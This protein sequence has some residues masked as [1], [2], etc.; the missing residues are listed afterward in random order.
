MVLI[1]DGA[2]TEEGPPLPP[3]PGF[4]VRY[5][6]LAGAVRNVGHLSSFAGP[7]PSLPIQARSTPALA[8]QN[9]GPQG[10]AASLEIVAEGAVVERRPLE[11]GPVRAPAR[12]PSATSSP[13]TR[14]WEARVGHDRRPAARRR[15]RHLRRSRAR[16]LGLRGGPS[17]AAPAG[18]ARRWSGSLSRRRAPEPE[19]RTVTLERATVSDAAARASP[20]GPATTSSSSTA[21]PPA[22]R[23][24]PGVTS[25]WDPH[26]EGSPSRCAAT[27]AIPVIAESRREHPL[28][29]Q[30][31]L[32]DVNI[33]EARRLTLAS[34]DVAVA[35]S[36]GVPVHH[37]PRAP[38][39]A[40][41]RAQLRS[42]AVPIC[43]CAPPIH[44]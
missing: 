22:R 17:P 16:R 9:F 21:S 8:V 30:V 34:G 32:A 31:D 18:V 14:A 43:R 15:R 37:C 35:G 4:D 13:P 40:R 19:A 29:R 1:S 41:R 42:L 24:R 38:R 44:C 25:I 20:P 36:F 5:L 27:D 26:G 23:P 10:V 6:P 39:T 11:L 33:A 7:P 28:L 3:R 12:E 2:F